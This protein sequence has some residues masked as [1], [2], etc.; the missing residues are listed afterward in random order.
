MSYKNALLKISG[1]ILSGDTSQT[2]DINIINQLTQDIKSVL[3]KKIKLSIVIGGG[4]IIRGI[5]HNKYNLNKND[6][7]NM[8]MLATVINGLYL[9]NAL[10]NIG[11]KS[12]V[13][14][15]IPISGIVDKFNHEIAVNEINNGYVLIFV[16]G[17]GN[18][19]FT[20]DTTSVLRALELGC[21]VLLKGTKVD[22]VYD[23]DP[24][25]NE[26]IKKFTKLN[27]NYIIQ[28]KLNIMDMSS[29]MMAED[30]NLPILVFSIKKKNEL[31]RVLLGK[32]DC[33]IIS[34]E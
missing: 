8:G 23:K 7:D 24:E 17:T 11:I 9:R 1:E 34:N 2:F 4:N 31:R 18:P 15:A 12:K 25:L 6:A 27:Y 5:N 32:G 29:I 28:N 21:D 19:Y 3:D 14:S 13:Y 26:N 10:N 16:G 30:G 22:G 33:T 20:T